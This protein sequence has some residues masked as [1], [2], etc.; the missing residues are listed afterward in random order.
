MRYNS[1]QDEVKYETLEKTFKVFVVLL[2]IMICGMA[3][4]ELNR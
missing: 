4:I 1:E 3:I 2:V